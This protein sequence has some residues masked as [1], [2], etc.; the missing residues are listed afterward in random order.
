MNAERHNLPIRTPGIETIPDSAGIEAAPF[1]FHPDMTRKPS[2]WRADWIWLNDAVYPHLQASRP[3]VFCE[4]A[5]LAPALALFRREF[6][7]EGQVQS[8]KAWVSGDVKYRLFVNG[9]PVGRGPAEVG[10]DYGNTETLG[11]WFY[12]GYDLSGR[13]VPGVNVIC[14]EVLLQPDVMADYSMAQGGFLLEIDW[15]GPDGSKGILLT[16]ESWKGLANPAFVDMT[17]RDAR[18]EPTGWHLAGF[19]DAGWPV[20][21]VLEKAYAEEA[22]Q[23]SGHRVRWPLL[24]REIPPMLEIRVLPKSVLE[25]FREQNGGLENPSALLA[26]SGEPAFGAVPAIGYPIEANHRSASIP[27]LVPFG[28]PM[29]FWLDFGKIHAGRLYFDLEGP[30]GT[31]VRFGFQEI[32]G[33]TDRFFDYALREGRQTFEGIRLESARYIQVTVSNLTGPVLLYGI[34]LHFSSYPV[35]HQGSFD[36]SDPDLVCIYEAGRWS[37]QICR[38]AHH[39]DSPI[40]QEA[41][42]CTGDYM[43]ESLMNYMTFGDPW[44]TRLDILRT[45][46]LL[47]RKD[48]AMFHTSY[49]LLWLQMLMDYR[50]FTGD[51]T[52]LPQMAQTA[53]RLLDRFSGYLGKSGLIESAPNYM[54]MDWVPVGKLNLHHPPKVL[55]QGYLS[56]F[57]IR[58]LDNGAALAEAL[59]DMTRADGFAQQAEHMRHAFHRELWDE[60]R[61]LYRDGKNGDAPSVPNDWLPADV[62]GPFY[63]QHTNSLAVLY[64]IAPKARGT[65]IMHRVFTDDALIQAQPYFMHFVLEAADTAGVFDTHG[66]PQMRRWTKLLAECPGSLKEVWAGFACDYSHAWGGTPTWQLP[67]KVLGITPLT[68]GFTRLRIR[69]CPG[70]LS[71]ACGAVPTPAGPVSVSWKRNGGKTMLE[72]KVPEGLDAVVE[73]DLLGETEVVV[74]RTLS[75]Q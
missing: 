44:L 25:P 19:D 71:W 2:P 48:S 6:R 13:L 1:S 72:I 73:P 5:G 28:V 33:R 8:A 75:G 40:H 12:D 35:R 51:E 29:T 69:P 22:A 20:V 58:A 14:A 70:D 50:L 68:P 41:L 9:E 59:G 23:A 3:T 43:I 31:Q 63:S 65:E 62:E 7:L 38:Q 32:A 45:A 57:L 16:D 4:G 10:G 27:A 47:D 15:I 66:N 26:G 11:Y 56:A 74:F 67:S 64:G 34:G 55:G 46:R 30:A 52:L 60:Q 39:L 36:C 24:P 42:G 37:N 18:Q 21:S 49:S 61:G 53:Y 54:F 17:F